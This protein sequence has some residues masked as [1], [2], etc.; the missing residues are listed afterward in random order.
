MPL[1]RVR[2]NAADLCPLLVDFPETAFV[3]MHIGYPYQDEYIALA[4]HY[5]NVHFDLCW[6]WI[7]NPLAAARFVREYLVAAPASKFL[8]FGGDY[9]NVETIVGHA[10]VAR[11]GL[12]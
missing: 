4:K 12:A 2:Q 10:K 6:A 9:A 5:A 7:I 11:L 1:E 8:T 3:L